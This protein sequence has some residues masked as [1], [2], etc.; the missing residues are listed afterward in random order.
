MHY[1]L[2]P[3]L[4][5]RVRT[6]M[7]SSFVSKARAQVCWSMPASPVHLRFSAHLVWLCCFA[8]PP[9]VALPGVFYDFP[10]SK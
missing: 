1:Q 5:P 3:P 6:A 7:T 8:Y 9:P 4:V 10:V 2:R